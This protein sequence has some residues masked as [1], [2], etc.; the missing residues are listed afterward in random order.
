MPVFFN[1]HRLGEMY[2]A[3]FRAKLDEHVLRHCKGLKAFSEELVADIMSELPSKTLHADFLTNRMKL[4]AAQESPIFG[5]ARVNF[6]LWHA[7]QAAGVNGRSVVASAF[8]EMSLAEQC[9][10]LKEHPKFAAQLAGHMLHPV[11]LTARV[12][13]LPIQAARG[14][15]RMT[16]AIGDGVD[17]VR[18]YNKGDLAYSLGEVAA[19]F[20][21]PLVTHNLT[22]DVCAELRTESKEAVGEHAAKLLAKR[23]EVLYLKGGEG[24]EDRARRAYVLGVN[25]GIN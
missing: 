10:H 12:I 2:K 22:T 3:V 23:G 6:E 4:V 11:K 18:Y 1:N 9:A 14:I 25:N 8:Q 16:K 15:G 5:A 7:G 24:F 13:N 20:E 21:D 17:Y 19:A